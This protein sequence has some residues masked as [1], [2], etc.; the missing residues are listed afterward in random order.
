MGS[1]RQTRP[2][3]GMAQ[4]TLHADGFINVV[5][6]GEG[7]NSLGPVQVFHANKAAKGEQ[8]FQVTVGRALG[9]RLDVR[10]AP[11]QE[12]TVAER[13]WSSI[14]EHANGEV[15]WAS[16]IKRD[17]WGALWRTA[18]V[19]NRDGDKKLPVEKCEWL[20]TAHG[21]S[22]H[23]RWEPVSDLEVLALVAKGNPRGAGVSKEWLQSLREGDLVKLVSRAGHGTASG[24]V[25]RVTKVTIRVKFLDAHGS[26]RDMSRATGRQIQRKPKQ[27]RVWRIGGPFFRANPRKSLPLRLSDAQVHQHVSEAHA[28]RGMHLVCFIGEVSPPG[29][30]GMRHCSTIT[31]PREGWQLR[32][33]HWYV[34]PAGGVERWSAR[35]LSDLE[36][37]AILGAR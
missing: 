15:V 32:E 6:V 34:S 7:E 17:R 13:A 16:P 36:A 37:L 8:L 24:Q 2:P 33:I 21:W 23:G 22:A 14:W 10:W 18:Y 1:R 25:I 3:V 26:V 19:Q 20:F 12:E 35:R 9:D 28:R 31:E 27:S 5:Y 11:V 4:G 29:R 30:E